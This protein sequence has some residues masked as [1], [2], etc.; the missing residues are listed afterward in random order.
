MLLNN[1]LKENLDDLNNQLKNSNEHITHITN[2]QVEESKIYQNTIKNPYKHDLAIMLNP[3][4]D[5]NSVFILLKTI[6]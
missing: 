6:I 2:I 3:N 4:L 5:E 1:Y